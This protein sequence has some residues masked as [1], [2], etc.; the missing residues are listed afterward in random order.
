MKIVLALMLVPALAAAAPAPERLGEG[1]LPVCETNCLKP[2][3]IPDRWDDVT[4]ISGHDD[5]RNNGRYD[6]ERLTGDVNENSLY[7]PGDAYDDANGNAEYD[8]EAYH[9]LLTGYIPD[10]YPG[11]TLS[12]NGDFGLQLVLKQSAPGQ[13]ATNQAYAL[14]LPATNRGTPRTGASAYRE[15]L[16][17]CLHLEGAPRDWLQVENGNMKGPTIAGVLVIIGKDPAARFDPAT[18]TIVGSNAPEGE[19]ARIIIVPLTD[20]RILVKGR[21]QAT[22]LVAFFL[23]EVND[24]GIVRGR[25]IKVPAPGTPCPGDIRANWLQ[26]CP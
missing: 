21:L 26:N 13:A 10:P 20:P 4:A 24:E 16:E 3:A 23:E 19:S 8:A 17:N 1:C 25:F 18:N 14:D 9:P 7:D 15:A 2:F 12:P 5:W 6:A 22:K 11:N